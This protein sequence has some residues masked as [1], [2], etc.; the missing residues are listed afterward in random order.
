[1]RAKFIQQ[2]ILLVG[3]GIFVETDNAFMYYTGLDMIWA[4]KD[5][6]TWWMNGEYVANP[7]AWALAY[8]VC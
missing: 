3:V 6:T 5:L 4:S 1:M 8:Q 2:A 7:I